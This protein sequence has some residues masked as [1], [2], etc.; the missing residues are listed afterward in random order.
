MAR[1]RSIHPKACTSRKLAAVSSDAE[2]LYWRLQTH[3][4]DD[5]RCED[6]P[7]VVWMH[8][9]TH[10]RGWSEDLVDGFLSELQT[11]GLLHRY[12][13]A[14]T[15]A[16]EVCGWSD[17]QHPRKPTPSSFAQW[18]ATS[19]P[20]LEP[21]ETPVTHWSRTGYTP[22]RVGEG[23]EGSGTGEERESE[24]ESSPSTASVDNE[25]VGDS[26]DL[27][28]DRRAARNGVA[29]AKEAM[30]RQNVTPIL[31]GAS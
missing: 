27:G 21:V 23:V 9:C 22:V 11:A 26:V 15:P 3:C 19:D 12:D 31:K 2:R 28:V 7:R 18:G 14:G 10:I 20:E 17:F 6:D 29:A 25:V 4:D 13:A 1:I 24:G 8:C 30:Q 5:G 16:I